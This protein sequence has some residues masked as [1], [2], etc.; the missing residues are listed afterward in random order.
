MPDPK[1]EDHTIHTRNR[2]IPEARAHAKA[3]KP[4]LVG[5]ATAGR[6]VWQWW[7]PQRGGGRCRAAAPRL[8][9]AWG[10]AGKFD[11]A[12]LLSDESEILTM[13]TEP[14]GDRVSLG[15]PGRGDGMRHARD[16]SG[17][18]PDKGSGVPD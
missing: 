18:M 10:D 1:E 15:P 2:G 9:R 3:S 8:C 14:L 12:W 16:A 11:H 7:S 17:G 5:Q 6:L 13:E 4:C